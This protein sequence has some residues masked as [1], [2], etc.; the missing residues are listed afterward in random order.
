MHHLEEL[1]VVVSAGSACHAKAGGA[2]PALTAIGLRGDEAKRMLRFSFSRDTS[3]EEVR[4]AADAL[5]SVCR[6]LES[7]SP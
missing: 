6:K 3:E 7:S 4:A 2:S 1:G 5:E